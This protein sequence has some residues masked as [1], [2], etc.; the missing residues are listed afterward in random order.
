MKDSGARHLLFLLFALS[1]FSGL[2]YESIWSHYLKL[3]LGH[4]AY[5]QSL[6]LVIFMGGMAVG[7]W[8]AS[9]YSVTWKNLLLAYAVV[10]GVIGI[11]GIVFHRAFVETTDI[12]YYTI[13]PNIGAIALAQATKWT[14]A[15]LLVLPQSILLGT[16]FPLLSAGM[17]RAFPQR[18]G[19]MLAMLYFCNS[20]GAAIGVLVSGFVLIGAVGLPGTI[21][22]AGLINVALALVVW[23]LVR[24]RLPTG[25]ALVSTPEPLP[26]VGHW[27]GLL[28]GAA[29]LTGVASFV[30]EIGWIRMLSLVLGSSTHAFELMLSAFIFGLAFGG[31]WVRRRIDG[32]I[33]SIRFLGFVQ[34]AMGVLAMSTLLVY[35]HS[36]EFV[37]WSLKVLSKTDGG[38]AV[39]NLLSHLVALAV[40]LPATFCAGMTLPLITYTLL[41]RGHGEKSIGTVYAANTLGGIIGV[42]G[43][44]HLAMPVLGLKGLIVF[45]ATID[46]ALGMALL[47]RRAQP[48]GAV[49]AATV[50]GA[51]ALVVTVA[52]VELDAY[53]MA[54]GVYRFGRLLSASSSEIRYHRDGKTATVDVI[55]HSDSGQLALRTNGKTD[56]EITIAL[57]RPVGGDEPTMVM[58]GALPVALHPG[59]KSA[60]VVGM[61]A[62][63]TTQTLLAASQLER[64]DTIE[65]EP[66]MVAAANHFRPRVEA[67]FSDP[68]SRIYIDDA[69]AY[70]AT[71]NTKYDI[72]VSEPSNP[73]VSGVAGLFSREFYGLV[74][75]YLREH[76]VFVQWLQ[77]YEIDAQLVASVMKA[78]GENFSDYAI[79]APLDWDLVIVARNDGRLP[80]ADARIL[81]MPGVG[82]ALERIGIRSDRD[83]AS[84]KL[85][86]KAVL[87]PLFDSFAVPANSD[88]FPVLDLNAA[89]TRFLGSAAHAFV[90]LKRAP[91]PV[92]ELPADTKRNASDAQVV[93]RND[94]Q[95]TRSVQAAVVLRDFYMNGN[96]L[97]TNAHIPAEIRK[98]MQLVS[99]MLKDCQHADAWQT[100]F[101]SLHA[102]AVAMLPYLTP[103]EIERLWTALDI[104]RCGERIPPHRRL[105]LSLLKAVGDRDA[106][107]MARSASAILAQ[108]TTL[109]ATHFDYVLA[110]GMLGHVASG[111]RSEARALW[112]RYARRAT[113]HPEPHMLFRLLLAHAVHVP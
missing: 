5:A 95:V 71:R 97:E 94:L 84:R 17:L 66:A 69:K 100:W 75:R 85:A 107:G 36:F 57:D 19:A 3:F 24:A 67:A 13:L 37:Q 16:T 21:L 54:S 74:R 53:K 31:L 64:V 110:A 103:A 112:T 45:G 113:R 68:R 78:L 9:R 61:G 70:F 50:I 44:L 28:L 79:Y 40:M 98:D 34:I 12:A 4:A 101:D 86:D 23:L 89:K 106:K 96:V 65:I 27:Y 58:M 25:E 46:I 109:P 56:A 30:Y 105:W 48:V 90:A 38:Y 26:T 18:P 81:R 1:G 22:T 77:L 15:A 47:W 2:V 72:I 35:A 32:L 7:S 41:R 60:A 59:A 92:L 73:W 111:E 52:V 55:A 93:G 43:A 6:V 80:D 83:L 10:E 39:F 49:A 88:Y 42:V 51:A 108:E 62:G 29:L 91:L 8:I 102:V 63:V 20:I 104:D 87:G 99:L 14:I 11:F 76:G 33:D 82:Q